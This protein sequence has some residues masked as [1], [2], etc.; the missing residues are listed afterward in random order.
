MTHEDAVKFLIKVGEEQE[1][2]DKVRG[3]A[4]EQLLALGK[5][6]GFEFSIEELG[7]AC[8]EIKQRDEGEISEEDLKDVAGGACVLAAISASAAI[9]TVG[10][11]ESWWEKP[12][13]AAPGGSGRPNLVHD[14][15]PGP[16]WPCLLGRLCR[17]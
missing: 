6:H 13:A 14:R 17:F 10:K 5:E 2:L 3:L 8:E 12:A 11:A 9:Y 7:E 16:S 4:Q 15:A 1:L